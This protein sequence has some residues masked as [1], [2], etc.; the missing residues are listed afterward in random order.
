MRVTVPAF[1]KVL[2][3]LV[4]EVEEGHREQMPG[5]EGEGGE[6]CGV[7]IEEEEEEEDEEQERVE[8]KEVEKGGRTEMEKNSHLPPSR[9]DPEA[10]A[11]VYVTSVQA[12]KTTTISADGA[13]DRWN[14]SLRGELALP[15]GIAAV[16][17]P[18][19]RMPH[20]CLCLRVPQSR[21][22]PSCTPLEDLNY[23]RCVARTRQC[24]MS[25]FGLSV[26]VVCTCVLI[27]PPP[28]H[29][30]TL[31]PSPVYVVSCGC[32]LHTQHRNCCFGCRPAAPEEGYR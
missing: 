9:E 13:V 28:C 1:R 19:A 21:S 3:Q 22:P 2:R 31:T 27:P 11:E 10:L 16:D 17:S 26:I 6:E 12:R 4:K 30:L 29:R 15:S 14:L 8:E 23:Y 5:E 24:S 25:P 32:R 18:L 20:L 7:E